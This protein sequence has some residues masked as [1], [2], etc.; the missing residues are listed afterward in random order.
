[1]RSIHFLLEDGVN[2]R[3]CIYPARGACRAPIYISSAQQSP[4]LAALCSACSEGLLH[5]KSSNDSRETHRQMK[6]PGFNISWQPWPY[7]LNAGWHLDVL[8][9]SQVPADIEST[10]HWADVENKLLLTPCAS[11]KPTAAL[12]P[13]LHAVVSFPSL[14]HRRVKPR[15]LKTSGSAVQSEQAHTYRSLPAVCLWFS[16]TPLIEVSV[17]PLKML[18][19]SPRNV[20]GRKLC[21]NFSI[22]LNFRL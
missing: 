18:S 7:P 17:Y 4:R 2:Y 12:T 9:S 14:I 3:P 19:F 1:M 11:W 10:C 8:F 16:A 5:C 21:P 6:F 13:S 15:S 22:S 20:A